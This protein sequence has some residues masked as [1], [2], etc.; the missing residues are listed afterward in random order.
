MKNQASLVLGLGL[1]LLAWSAT[2]G[3]LS[4]ASAATASGGTRTDFALFDGTNPAADSDTGAACGAKLGGTGNNPVAFTYHVTVSNHS[5]TARVLRIVYRDGDFVRYWIPP[6]TSF[7]LSQ[8][9]GGTLGVDDAIKVLQEGGPGVGLAG[10][11]SILTESSAKPNPVVGT[12]LCV[13]LTEVV[14]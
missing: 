3:L 5:E 4:V 14:P 10:S 11:M 7:S 9:A 1:T 2:P 8:A 13:T 6:F 12:S